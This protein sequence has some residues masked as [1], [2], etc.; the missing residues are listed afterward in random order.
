MNKKF[1]TLITSIFVLFFAFSAFNVQGQATVTTD[2]SD[3][4][5]GDTLLING[6]GWLPGEIVKLNITE[7][8]ILCP[9]GHN[10]YATADEEGKIYN[11][12]FLFNEKHLV[13]S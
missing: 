3:Y 11:S 13:L 8:P 2:R 1:I 10:L 9:N 6:T 7:T 5:P 12:Q 4:Q